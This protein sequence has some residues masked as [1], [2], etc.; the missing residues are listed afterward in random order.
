MGHAS[1]G[2]Q[3][4]RRNSCAWLGGEGQAFCAPAAAP[5]DVPLLS[6]L[7]HRLPAPQLAAAAA[8]AGL[9]SAAVARLGRLLHRSLAGVLARARLLLLPEVGLQGVPGSSRGDSAE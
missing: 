1:R 5:S 8:A 3:A 2:R 9:A 4:A 7:V 6:S